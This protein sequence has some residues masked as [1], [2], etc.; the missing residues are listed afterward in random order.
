ME[1]SGHLH[2][3]T[4]LPTGQE[5]TVATEYVK[6]KYL[7]HRDSNPDPSTVV[8]AASRYTH[9]AHSIRKDHRR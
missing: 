5:P 1:E 3:S 9:C 2:A 7:S 4:A 8:P 6:F